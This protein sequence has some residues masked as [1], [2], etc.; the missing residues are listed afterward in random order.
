MTSYGLL[1]KVRTD[2]GGENIRVWV[3]MIDQH[4]TSGAGSST[5]NERMER[6]WRDVHRCVAVLHHD[7]FR[8]LEDEDLLDPLNEI[9]LFCLHYISASNKLRNHGT[10]IL[11]PQSITLH[12]IS[13]LYEVLLRTVLYRPFLSHM[14]HLQQYFLHQLLRV[15]EV[16]RVSFF[17]CFL[18]SSHISSHVNP[19]TCV[20]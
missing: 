13:R 1:E 8:Q 4:N 18:L 15:F 19:L 17:P 7:L 20:S 12:L 11:Y 2:H 6:L 16:P 3:Y 5:H 10:I 14:V 9:D